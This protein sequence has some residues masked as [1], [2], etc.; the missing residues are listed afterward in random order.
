MARTSRKQH[1]IESQISCGVKEKIYR[2]AVYVRLSVEDIRKKISDSIGTQK[3][4]LINFVQNQPDLQLFDVYEDVNYTGTNFNRP[5]FSRM[6]ADIQAGLVDCVIV[7][8]LSRFGRS[9]E[10]MGHYLERVFQFLQ[11][12]FISVGDSYDSMTALLD[13]SSLIVPLKNLMNEIYARDISKKVKSGKKVKQQRGEFCGAFAPYGYIKVGPSFVLDEEIAPV[14]R[15]IFDWFLA[16]MSETKIAQKLNELKILP[17]SRY[18]FEKGITKAKKHEETSYWYKSAIVRMIVNP[19]YIGTMASGKYQSNFLHGGGV[20]TKNSDEWLIFEDAHPAI[21]DRDVFDAVQKK[22]ETRKPDE[23][24]PV[25]SR[26]TNI[27]KGL[28]FCGDCGK[29]MARKTARKKFTFTCSVY[30]QVDKTACTMKPIREA[31]LQAAL[32]AYI[33]REISLVGDMSHLISKL[34]KRASYKAQR[35]SYERQIEV[36]QN[37]LTQNRRFRGSLREDYQDGILS[38]QDY[39]TMKADYDEEKDNLQSELEL[40]LIEKSRQDTTV[41]PENKWIKEFRRFET[42][43]RLS[44]GMVAALVDRIDVYDGAR[45]EVKLKYRDELKAL[46][47]YINETETKAEDKALCGR[48]CL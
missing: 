42:E 43:Q 19:A 32:Y 39:I 29:H 13:D 8:D 7:K 30:D 46:Q 36:L 27:F 25:N 9:F 21:I 48:A 15:N 2:V 1:N 41:S 38:E 44:A 4:L 23:E 12:R 20:I 35:T 16:G 28:I 24:K 6:I 11:V 47:E 40:L 5:G 34:Q 3:A 18:R 10:E 14:V 37:K 33:S 26:E 45:I 17:P 31:D 22:L